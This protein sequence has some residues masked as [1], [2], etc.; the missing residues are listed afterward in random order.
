MNIGQ[1]AQASGVSAKMIRY[2]EEIG[3]IPVAAR[4]GA[5][6]R[7]YT[8]SDVHRL[9]F[10]RRARDLGF[11]V[12][13]IAELLSLWSDRSR[14]SAEVKR[15]AQAHIDDLE[16]KI[17]KLRGMVDTLQT[18]VECCAGDDRPECPI[19]AELE[20]PGTLSRA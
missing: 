10:V 15:I 16:Q 6:Y 13:E 7:F 8:Q 2:Y 19:L 3:L 1:A 20:G 5:G 14:Q 9:S 18:L 12:K 4:N 11:S 17:A